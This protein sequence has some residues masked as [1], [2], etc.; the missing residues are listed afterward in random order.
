[1]GLKESLGDAVNNYREIQRERIRW[2]PLLA[3]FVVLS[4]LA[5]GIK[6]VIVSG[7]DNLGGKAT[8]QRFYTGNLVRLIIMCLV[9]AAFTVVV[10]K[11]WKGKQSSV[12]QLMFT[13]GSGVIV[14][15][16]A[17]TALLPVLSIGKE[18]RHPR[19]VDKSS[20]TLCTAG[21][22][23]YVAFDDRGAVLLEIPKQ[24]YDELSQGSASDK[25]SAGEA[26]MLVRESNYN[27]VRF[28]ESPIKITYYD[29]SII[30]ESIEFKTS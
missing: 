18:L 16:F 30:Y 8:V 26:N 14:I 11:T 24:K 17:I 5:S 22:S 27:N 25:R 4:I 15:F 28:Y 19:N 20:Y 12:E 21:N 23:Y 29:K 2:A 1:M 6:M 7:A 3:I 10:F 13:I 9:V